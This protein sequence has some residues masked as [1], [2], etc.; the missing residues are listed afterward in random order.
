MT[1]LVNISLANNALD[2]D[3]DPIHNAWI[4]TGTALATWWDA[5]S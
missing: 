4:E 1:V 3:V 2:R 5:I